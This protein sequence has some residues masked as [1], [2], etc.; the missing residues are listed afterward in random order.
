MGFCPGS[1]DKKTERQ[2]KRLVSLLMYFLVGLMT[3]AD[4]LFAATQE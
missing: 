2:V 1:Q 4:L 3:A